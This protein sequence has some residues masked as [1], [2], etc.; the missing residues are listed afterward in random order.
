[1]ILNDSQSESRRLE[2]GSRDQQRI[3]HGGLPVLSRPRR[4]ALWLRTNG[5]Q[6]DARKGWDPIL[7][8]LKMVEN[9]LLGISWTR[10]ARNYL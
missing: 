6:N 8:Q 9:K 4:D 10:W 3:S 7:E 2:A 5:L 1:M